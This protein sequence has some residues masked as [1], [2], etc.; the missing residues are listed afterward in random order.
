ML[1]S[2]EFISGMS[3][4]NC[5]KPHLIP[6]AAFHFQLYMFKTGLFFGFFFHKKSELELFK[7]GLNPRMLCSLCKC[8]NQI[9]FQVDC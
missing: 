6:K 5:I 3:Q 8:G 7:F 9:I 1:F 4:F 2:T